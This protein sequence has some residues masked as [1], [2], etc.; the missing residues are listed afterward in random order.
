MALGIGAAFYYYTNPEVAEHISRS[1][2]QNFFLSNMITTLIT[3]SILFPSYLVC[4]IFLSILCVINVSMTIVLYYACSAPFELVSLNIIVCIP[5]SLLLLCYSYVITVDLKETGEKE[6]RVRSLFNISSE[7]LIIHK[8]GILMDVNPTFEKMFQVTEESILY[9][10]PAAIWEFLPD[11]DRS[12]IRQRGRAGS[13]T[14]T[15]N[16]NEDEVFETYGTNTLGE[17]FAVQVKAKTVKHLSG[18]VGIL[19]IIDTRAQKKLM[20]ADQAL[21]KAEAISDAKINFLTT[22][23]HEVRTPINGILASVE[24]VENTQLD[25]TQ[26]DFLNCI[27]D[28]ANYLLDL[29]T[30][31]LDFSKIEAGRMEL[32]K[33]EFNMITMLEETM[34]IVCRTAQE[35]ELEMLLMVDPEVPVVMIGDPYRVKQILLNFLSNA[36]KCTPE[37]HVIVRVKL[38]RS[39]ASTLSSSVVEHTV[40]FEVED[41]GIGIKEEQ[42]DNLFTAFLQLDGSQ[43]KF[44]G[45][46]LGLSISKRLCSLM[47]GEIGVQS[48][49]GNGSTFWFTSVL[50]SN[51]A[52]LTHGT[53]C[54]SLSLYNSNNRVLV[55][56]NNEQFVCS[57]IKGYVLD[58]NPNVCN[59]AIN[60]FS[61][62]KVDMMPLHREDELL[63]LVQDMVHGS[64]NSQDVYII[65]TPE[66]QASTVATIRQQL[67]AAGDTCPLI[68][69]ILI[70]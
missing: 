22:V 34:N 60:Y 61:M 4:G 36:I 57:R 64:V 12:M 46:G 55:H 40:R 1:V 28:S 37:G 10:V 33:I 49:Y 44:Q 13:H 15:N 52:S 38:S 21:R 54:Q 5:T 31:I 18:H 45:T 17:N 43:K 27:K 35:R 63:A 39:A 67:D 42:I 48:K 3:T 65:L 59:S 20:E 50:Q 9:P 66:L 62:M 41:S 70:Q 53:L 24:I 56:T 2:F 16:M 19:S 32:Q 58:K 47:G 29:I 7:A 26:R 69:W 14:S 68:Y 6:Q 30:A 8:D 23:S 51:H 25:Y 11:F